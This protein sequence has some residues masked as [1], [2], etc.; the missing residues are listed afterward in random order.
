MSE[1]TQ[2]PTNNR[3]IHNVTETIKAVMSSK[4][5]AKLGALFINAIKSV[6]IRNILHET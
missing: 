1:K 6:E 3:A 4:A 2:F 5:K